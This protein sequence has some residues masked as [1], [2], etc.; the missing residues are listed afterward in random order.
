MDPKIRTTFR[1]PENL[2]IR[3]RGGSLLCGLS[4][5]PLVVNQYVRPKLKNIHVDHLEGSSPPSIFV[6]RFGYPKLKI[7]PSS[8]P[9]FGD[10]SIYDDPSRWLSLDLEEFLS[11]RLMLLRGSREIVAREAGNPSYFLQNMQLLSL[12]D[13]PV[14]IEMKYSRGFNSR[15]VVLSEHTPPM[16]PSAPLTDIRTDNIKVVKSFEKA[17][18]DTDLKASEAVWLLYKESGTVNSLTKGLSTGS[19]GTGKL[20]R[21]VPTRW[22]ITAVDKMLSDRLVG[23]LKGFNTIDKYLVFSRKVKGNLFTAVL[24][25]STWSFEWGEAWF[26]GSTWNHFGRNPQ[27]MIDYEGYWG[28]KTYP[29]I[30]GCYYA[31]RLSAGEYLESIG[32]QASPLLWREIYPGFNIPVGVWFVRENLRKMFKEKPV[33]FDTLEQSLGYI[34]RLMK[35][36]L[37]LWKK[38][39]GLISM[40]KNRTLESFY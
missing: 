5:C 34:S 25:P 18:Y 39:S 1:I 38:K 32:R 37:S 3:C 28:R 26:P 21:L 2:C 6:G 30:G 15:E 17:Y 31:S 9:L 16:G 36:P 33:I 22:A 10:T 24:M 35:V 8:P 11:M 29:E 12:S 7:Y 19:F 40:R 4:Y 27:L 23:K 20:R 13:K 14:D